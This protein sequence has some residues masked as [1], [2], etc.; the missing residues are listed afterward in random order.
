LHEY[1]TAASI[2]GNC[3]TRPVVISP[4]A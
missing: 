3:S 4:T 1:E 2:L